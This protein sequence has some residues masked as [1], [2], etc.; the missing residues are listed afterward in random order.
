MA[1]VPRSYGTS[2]PKRADPRLTDFAGMDDTWIHVG[3]NH[4]RD[5]RLHRPLHRSDVY[6]VHMTT[7]VVTR[8]PVNR[9]PLPRESAPH[10]GGPGRG[11]LL[12]GTSDASHL[13]PKRR[14]HLRR[15]FFFAGG[16]R[17]PP[18]SPPARSR[19]GRRRTQRPRSAPRP[20]SRSARAVFGAS[21]SA[22]VALHSP[23]PSQPA[24]RRRSLTIAGSREPVACSISMPAGKRQTDRETIISLILCA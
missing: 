9:C 1:T 8:I 16:F 13:G 17:F 22:H 2:G 19:V 12:R 5:R 15:L 11:F 21:A 24:S 10:A 23:W 7:L 20:S 3:S 6:G 18:A 4:R 14:C